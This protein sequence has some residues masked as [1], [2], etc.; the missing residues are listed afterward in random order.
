M[1]KLLV[2]VIA[3]VCLLFSLTASSQE[4]IQDIAGFEKQDSINPPVKGSILLIGSSSF[5]KWT[6]VQAYFPEYSIIN[7]GFGGSR[8]TDL[9]YYVDRLVPPY[10]PKQ[11]LIYCGENDFASDPTVTAAVVVE[12]FKTLFNLIRRKLPKTPIY[13][14]SMKP[15]P[16]RQLMLENFRIANEGIRKF[17]VKKKRTGYIDVYKEM[18]DDEG[19]PRAELFLN[20]NLHMKKEGYVIWQRII[21]PYLIK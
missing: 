10:A 3:G 12:R 19:K 18:I 2:S 17:L 8:L 20:D 9:I 16:S 7:R 1:K 11:I 5:T 15:S 13:F 6:D 21:A 4:F 14:I